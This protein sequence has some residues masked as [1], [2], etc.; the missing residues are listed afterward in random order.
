MSQAQTVTANFSAGPTSADLQVT[1]SDGTTS[2]V[3]GAK[4]TYTITT[5]NAGP[6]YVTGVVVK[7]TFPTTFTG[8]TYTATEAG[9]A[10]G[11]PQR[12]WQHQG[13]HHDAAGKCSHLQG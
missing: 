9:G 4:N 11:F 13:Y 2:A 10:T 12:Q 8:V 5:S 7:D 6:S 3:A 1:V